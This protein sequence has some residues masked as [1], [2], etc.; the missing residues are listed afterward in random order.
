MFTSSLPKDL[1]AELR[2]HLSQT[3]RPT[4]RVVGEQNH[5][6]S[7]H[8][9]CVPITES[10]LYLHRERYAPNSLLRKAIMPDAVYSSLAVGNSSNMNSPSFKP[11]KRR[12]L[13]STAY[14]ADLNRWYLAQRIYRAVFEDSSLALKRSTLR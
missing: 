11:L 3:F 5:R 7:Y 10:S 13:S 12:K 1:I 8:L 2:G 6:C 4:D 9:A 14:T